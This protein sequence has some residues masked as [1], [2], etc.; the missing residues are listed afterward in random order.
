[1]F[2]TEATSVTKGQSLWKKSTSSQEKEMHN[3]LKRR[4]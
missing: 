1:M 4:T 3:D 2:Y